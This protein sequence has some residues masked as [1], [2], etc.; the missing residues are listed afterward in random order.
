MF[1]NHVFCLLVE[2]SIAVAGAAVK[3]AQD[4]LGIISSP[5]E[6]EKYALSERDNAG[7]YFVPA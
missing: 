3:W 2:G 7:V 6:I 5:P 4:N 1:P